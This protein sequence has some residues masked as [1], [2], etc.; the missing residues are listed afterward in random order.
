[1]KN[2]TKAALIITL[3]LVILGSAF[4]A[5]GMGIGFSFPEFWELRAIFQNPIV[6]P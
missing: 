1:M 4:C 3:V 6:P 5:V 2:F